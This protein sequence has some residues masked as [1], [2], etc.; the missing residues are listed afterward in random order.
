MADLSD[1]VQAFAAHREAARIEGARAMQEKVIGVVRLVAENAVDPIT[2]DVCSQLLTIT[3]AF[4]PALVVDPRN[5]GE[6]AG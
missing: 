2:R 3:E 6:V 4:D 1:A 5:I